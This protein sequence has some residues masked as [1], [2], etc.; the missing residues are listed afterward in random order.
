VAESVEWG[1]GMN[2]ICT[3]VY[4]VAI[5]YNKDA[6]RTIYF[7]E[8]GDKIYVIHCF[9]KKSKT[10]IKTPREEIVVIDKRLKGLRLGQHS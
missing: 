7:I 5:R 4:E 1:G 6:Y 2:G 9:Q 10:G 3:G 8:S